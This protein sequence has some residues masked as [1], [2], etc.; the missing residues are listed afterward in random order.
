VVGF[1]TQCSIDPIRYAVW[2]SKANFTYRVSLFA[3]HMVVHFLDTS[4]HDVAELFGG[5]SGDQTDKFAHCEWTEGPSGVPILERCPNRMILERESMW[6]DGSDHVCFV[7]TPVEASA[8]LEW[9]P[10]RLSGAHD[11]P[12]GHEAEERSVPSTLT[13][14][15]HRA[16]GPPE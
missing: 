9:E 4:D 15:P 11:I 13:A 8:P 6:D 7:G 1:H 16:A 14:R 10:M 5:T 2:L 12:A 3:T